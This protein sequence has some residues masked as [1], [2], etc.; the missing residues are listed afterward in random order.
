MR[1][2]DTGLAF[3]EQFLKRCPGARSF[4]ELFEHL[5]STFFYAKD[6]L[7]RYVG[8]NRLNLRE[9]FGLD[10][11]ED[12]LGKTDLDFQP[13]ALAEAYHAEDR[14]VM[15][16]RKP[17][18]GQVWLVPHV[19][20]TP[21]WYV[22][23]KTPMFDSM[24][25]VIGIAGVMYSIDEPQ[26]RSAYFRELAPVIA[27]MEK[28]YAENIAMREMA[29]M[30]GMSST[31]FNFRFQQILHMSPTEH[32]LRLRLDAAKRMLTSSDRKIAEVA[33]ECGFWDQS[34]FGKRFQK[35]LGMTP[36]AY[37]AKFR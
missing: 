21:K 4:F 12:L 14:K 32:L 36:R 24:N 30:I 19:R 34:H 28:H 16:T 2:R 18:P 37:R 23:S 33:M 11:L 6:H 26:D 15:D 31:R 1:N 3:Q 27:Y 10:C 29:G 25:R 7:H 9:V 22:S 17:L 5:P 35:A 13:P 8:A 20:G